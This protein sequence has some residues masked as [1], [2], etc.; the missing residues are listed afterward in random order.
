MSNSILKNAY[1]N[2][3]LLNVNAMI[4]YLASISGKDLKTP[5]IRQRIS[6]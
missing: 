4:K 2:P 3:D 5:F 1:N 6:Q